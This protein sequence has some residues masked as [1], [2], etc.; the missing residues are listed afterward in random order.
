MMSVRVAVEISGMSASRLRTAR[1]RKFSKISGR[2]SRRS[3][4]DGTRISTTVAP[5]SPASRCSSSA[6]DATDDEMM[7][8]SGQRRINARTSSICSG[9]AHSTLLSDRSAGP[10]GGWRRRTDS[11]DAYNRFSVINVRGSGESALIANAASF[12]PVP[13][14]PCRWT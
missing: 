6:R 13:F 2:S 3:S 10:W 1:R 5:P 4:S 12:F 8:N 14:G 9:V 7:R 11:A